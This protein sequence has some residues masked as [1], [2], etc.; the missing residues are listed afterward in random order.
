MRRAV[1]AVSRALALAAV[2][3]LVG[4]C[5]TVRMEPPD[6]DAR[7]AELCRA[8]MARLPDSLYGQ[9]RVSVEPDSDLVAAWGS[10]TIAVRCGVERPAGLRLDSQLLSVNDVA[11]LPEPADSPTLF[12]A[13]GREAY[14]ELTLPA[15]YTPPAAALTTLSDL[16]REE[17]P[18]LPA[19][20]L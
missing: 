2:L 11:W 1:R 3:A 14:V 9:E 4:G 20:E 7:T 13:V 16:V 18:A 6:P 8:V 17:I 15:T 12:T 10:P 5:G 19:G